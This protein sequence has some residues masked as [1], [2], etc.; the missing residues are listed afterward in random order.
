[1]A[2][3]RLYKM[4]VITR[5]VEG[6]LAEAFGPDLV[7]SDKFLRTYGFMRV[8][9]KVVEEM[10]AELLHL[11]QNAVEGIN[12]YIDTH[13]NDLPV[14]FK[15]A[16]HKPTK[17]TVEHMVGYSRL[18]AHD[19]QLAW[20]PEVIF[21]KVLDEL[22]E[23]MAQE[24]FPVYP[25]TKPYIVPKIPKNFSAI[26]DLMIEQEEKIREITGAKGSHIGSNSWVVSGAKTK[27]GKPILSNDPHLGFSQPAVWYDIHLVG[28][29]FDVAGVALAGILS[30]SLDRTST[31]PGVL[32]M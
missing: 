10:D 23:E 3:E 18:M 15:I 13:E 14:E 25:D 19:L 22:G 21:G 17:W 29:R 30:S 11:L 32:P 2:S 1:M 26:A 12:Y 16:G 31:M 7:E 9:K 28:G 8:S 20:L 27:S 5:A 4:D 6:R 24:L